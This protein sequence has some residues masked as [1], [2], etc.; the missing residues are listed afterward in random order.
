MC[1]GAARRDQG[2]AQPDR[3]GDSGA[4]LQR[5]QGGQ[6]R[7]ERPWRQRPRHRF[8]LVPGE[9]RQ[10]VTLKNLLGLVG[11]QHRITVEGNPHFVNL[12]AARGFRQRHD[13]GRRKSRIQRGAYV[14]TVHRQK[15]VRAQRIEIAKGRTA[16]REHAALQL[17]AVMGRR[18]EGAQTRHRIVA[19]QQHHFDARRVALI[20]RQEF[21]HQRKGNTGARRHIQ[22]RKLQ[23]HVGAVVLRLEKLVFFFEIEQR[24][25]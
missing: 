8:D 15:Q 12:R 3:Q 21:L 7:F 6:Q 10:A 11:K 2:G 24:A 5:V 25:R 17:Q 20:E 14:V 13:P 16:T 9:G 19:R 23:L 4:L 1:G 22:T 18:A